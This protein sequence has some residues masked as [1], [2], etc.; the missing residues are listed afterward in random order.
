MNIV[1]VRDIAKELG[2]AGAFADR[3]AVHEFM[4]CPV[5][6]LPAKL[7]Q[8]TD[9]EFHW[10]RA[11]LTSGQSG[12][13]VVLPYKRFIIYWP[14]TGAEDEE[15]SIYFVEGVTHAIPE[16]GRAMLRVVEHQH[17][18]ETREHY[19]VCVSYTGAEINGARVNI[20]EDYKPRVVPVGKE[21]FCET[22]VA[23]IRMTVLRLAY[24]VMSNTSAVI[25]VE[26]KPTQGKS[27]EWHLARTHYCLITKKQAMQIRDKRGEIG[28]HDIKRA[29]HWRRAHFKTLRAAKWTHKRGQTVPV[30]E[31][32]V[33]PK[34]WVGLDGKIYK[35]IEQVKR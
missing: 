31:A 14:A 29:A 6:I 22:V 33:G 5:F 4:H 16:G 17:D 30:I 26:P 8:M 1:K 25:R 3:V 27:V 10:A 28:S 20:F 21:R 7:R 15:D 32:W 9:E 18:R 2:R 34:E 11:N 13:P 24:D 23:Q 35:V 12:V 19:S